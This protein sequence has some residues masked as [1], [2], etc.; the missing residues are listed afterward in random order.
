VQCRERKTPYP[1]GICKPLQRSATTDRTLVAGAGVSGSSPLV[2]SP[3]YLQN[4]QKQKAFDQN[5]GDFVSSTSAVDY[6]KASSLISVCCKWLQGIAGGVGGSSG[7]DRL[8]DMP[9]FR[10][11]RHHPKS[12]VRVPRKERTSPKF[13]VASDSSRQRQPLDNRP[14]Y[15]SLGSKTPRLRSGS[16]TIVYQGVA[17]R[18]SATT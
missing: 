2:G 8:T 1:C 9:G 12:P 11:V 13:V 6:P 15:T 18:N 16:C 3:F 7:M 17:F 14:C 4:P 10:W 5:I